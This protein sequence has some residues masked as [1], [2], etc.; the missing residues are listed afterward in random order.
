MSDNWYK[1]G[2]RAVD[3][4]MKEV[5]TGRLLEVWKQNPDLRFMQ[6]LGNVFRGD[7]YY[8]EDYDVIK[9]VEG[10]YERH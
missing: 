6:L 4:K 9:E 3:D 7:P 5:V 10:F 8:I 2:Q 1:G